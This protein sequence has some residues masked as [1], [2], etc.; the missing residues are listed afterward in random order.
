MSTEPIKRSV[1][2][3][4]TP[5]AVF[6][7]YTVKDHL[8]GWFAQTATVNAVDGGSWHFTWPP[9]MAASGRYLTVN[10]P[11]ELMWTWEESIQ[12]DTLDVQPEMD[13][14]MPV[15]TNRYVIEP[16]G[17]DAILHIEESGHKHE[18]IREMNVTGIDQMIDALR[19]W[20]EYGNRID[21]DNL[22]TE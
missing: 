17:E 12:D 19:V 11:H 13:F 1:K 7:A 18:D 10:R 6:D 9:H 22:P 3:A 20:L 4:A 8:E 14:E 16:D 21:W 5:E 2:F 15:V